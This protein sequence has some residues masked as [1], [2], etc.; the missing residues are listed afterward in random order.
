M[1]PEPEP[2]DDV[3]QLIIREIVLIIDSLELFL[4]MFDRLIDELLALRSIWV[5]ALDVNWSGFNHRRSMVTVVVIG[6]P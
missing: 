5:E 1:S 2:F 3:V 4:E 6:K